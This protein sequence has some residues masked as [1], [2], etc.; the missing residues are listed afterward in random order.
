MPQ[1]TNSF[2]ALADNQG[3]I[4]V[5]EVQGPRQVGVSVDKYREMES[6]ANDAVSKAEGYYKQLVDAG[7]IKPKLTTEQQLEALAQQNA[8]LSAQVGA[9]TAKIS[10]LMEGKHELPCAGKNVSPEEQPA[11]LES[12]ASAANGGAVSTDKKRRS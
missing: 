4:Y 8:T 7:L 3:N 5:Q 6:V 1:F 11:A 12:G 9:L 10:T 2:F